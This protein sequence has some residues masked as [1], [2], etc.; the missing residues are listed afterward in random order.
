M[1]YSELTVEEQIMLA[2]GFVGQG[3]NIPASLMVLLGPELCR[4]ITHPENTDGSTESA[5]TH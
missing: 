1:T 2:A 5:G 4:D 3:L